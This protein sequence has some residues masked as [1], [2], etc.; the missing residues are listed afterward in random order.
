MAGRVTIKEIAKELGLAHSTVSRVL[1]G[2]SSAIAVSPLMRQR[3]LDTV[4]KRGYVPNV[5]ARRLIRSKSS[6]MGV[7][8]PSEDM[9]NPARA[10]VADRLLAE[11]MSG[12]AEV[13]RRHDYR[14][15][16]VFND[17]RFVERREYVNLFKEGAVDGL[18]VWGA[19]N[20]E[21]FWDEASSLNVIFL[22][23]RNGASSKLPYVGSDNRLAVRDC[24]LRMLAAGRRSL[25]YLDG[26]E[27]LSISDERFAGYRDAL[28]EAGV[29]FKSKLCFR[30]SGA[31]SCLERFLEFHASSPGSIDALQCVNNSLAFAAGA[32]LIERGFSVPGD[33]F[34]AGG[35]GVADPYSLPL[36]F[37]IPM[38]S[39]RPACR[40]MGEIAAGWLVDAASGGAV[41]K[42][43]ELLLPVEPLK[44]LKGP[45]GG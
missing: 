24:C 5:N 39:Y 42:G 28:K 3:I 2:A 29:P 10:S 22:N 18:L 37:T 30:G 25:A 15:L 45:A 34:L 12:M 32:A 35:D 44:N 16:L 41:L 31:K 33:V 6:V 23:S 40:K 43:R 27:G 4:A 19:R 17:S 21:R 14:M 11:A 1:N 13:F 7:V 36:P 20:D 8:I 26:Y 9:A 38:I